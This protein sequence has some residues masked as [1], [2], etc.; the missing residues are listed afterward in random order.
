MN[1]IDL[2]SDSVTQPTQ[3]MR[4]AMYTRPV[5]DDQ[6]GDDPTVKNLEQ[7]CARK[8]GKEA[9]LFVASGTMGNQLAVMTHTVRGDEIIVSSGSHIVVHE[10]G[11]RA[12]LSG[13]NVRAIDCLNDLLTPSIIDRVCRSANDTLSPKT[14]LVC[15]ENAMTNG[16]VV[17][18]PQMRDIYDSAKEHN[19][20]VH[21]DGARLFN[22][23]VALGVDVKE[24]TQY[25]DSVMV[26]LSKGLCAPVGS[27][28]CGS[29]DFIEKA[30][31]NRK[32][33]GGGMAQ[34][35]ML[36]RCGII[37]LEK[38]VDRLA[39]DH[40][41]AK[42]MAQRLSKMKGVRVM[43]DNVDIN[44]VFFKVDRPKSFIA[45]LPSRMLD[46]GVKMAGE[47]FGLLRFITNNDVSRADVERVCDIF[48]KLMKE[49]EDL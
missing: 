18:V 10:V 31:R 24:I 48:E 11:A 15:I 5:G 17:T 37:A 26:C 46:Y 28:L 19:L 39:D 43:K 27:V 29:A 30:R 47:E 25:C 12:V 21:L 35:G 49:S 44:L 36:A 42:Y 34:A 40:A 1:Y 16:K 20:G 32:M 38:M 13:V 3:E 22:A 9:G 8:V 14:S 23:S 41:N 4:E 7:L 2:R 45:S 6:F 33:M